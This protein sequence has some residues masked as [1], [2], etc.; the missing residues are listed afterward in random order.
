MIILISVL[1]ILGTDFSVSVEADW[2]LAIVTLYCCIVNIAFFPIFH[3]A[4][5]YAKSCG[6]LQKQH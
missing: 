3:C 5:T 6:P 2:K 4:I 1:E